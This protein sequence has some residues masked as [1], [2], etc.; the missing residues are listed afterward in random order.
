MSEWKINKVIDPHKQILQ[1]PIWLLEA[2]SDT[3]GHA[4]F[5]HVIKLVQCRKQA[6]FRSSILQWLHT[7]PPKY[8]EKMFHR[9]NSGHLS[10]KKTRLFYEIHFNFN[11]NIFSKGLCELGRCS[12]S[13]WISSIFW[14][15]FLKI[16]CISWLSFYFLN[17]CSC[18]YSELWNHWNP[19][20]NP[21]PTVYQPWGIGESLLN[22]SSLTPKIY[23]I[24][25]CLLLL[26]FY[27]TIINFTER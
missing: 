5:C 11:I 7:L 14:I 6:T 22:I 3:N 4:I 21:H 25:V 15:K 8:E 19:G 18:W 12:K 16:Y 9:Y 13:F 24:N 26:L 27:Y 1:G 17:F 20:S 10:T 23:S 2:R